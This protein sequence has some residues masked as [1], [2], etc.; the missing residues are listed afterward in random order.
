MVP[1]VV[2]FVW[3]CKY[4]DE[5]IDKDRFEYGEDCKSSYLPVDYYMSGFM[6]TVLKTESGVF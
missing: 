3:Y 2:T 4:Y 6:K 5:Y 1:E